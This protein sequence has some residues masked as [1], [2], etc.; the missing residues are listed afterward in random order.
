[1]R[2]TLLIPLV[3]LA[4]PGRGSF[5]ELWVESAQ[6]GADG[7]QSLAFGPLQAAVATARQAL[8]GLPAPLRPAATRL[9]TPGLNLVQSNS[10]ALGLALCSYLLDPAFPYSGHIV[11]GG[12]AVEVT[13]AAPAR[14]IDSGH[15][16]HSLEA[17]CALGYQP[18]PVLFILPRCALDETLAERC[19]QLAALNIAVRPVADLAEAL[20]ACTGRLSV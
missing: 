14:I 12:L 2:K 19:G 8:A 11:T 7:L 13:P 3:D 16:R 17:V 20:E 4:K 6:Y 10:T 1:M 18:E 5:L 9:M 15:L